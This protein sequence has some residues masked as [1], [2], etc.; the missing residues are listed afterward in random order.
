LQVIMPASVPDGLPFSTLVQ[1]RGRLHP[2]ATVP[3]RHHHRLDEAPM[4][5]CCYAAWSDAG[6]V[7]VKWSIS[8]RTTPAGP[9]VGAYLLA[10]AENRVS[11]WPSSTATS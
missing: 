5:T 9:A 6:Y 1:P 2:A 8:S 7:G 11:T 4:A 3:E 10:S